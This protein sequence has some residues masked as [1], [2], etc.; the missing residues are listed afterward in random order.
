MNGME[1]KYTQEALELALRELVKRCA[2]AEEA[3]ACVKRILG[4][5]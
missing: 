3:R 2:S 4:G 1:S 5:F